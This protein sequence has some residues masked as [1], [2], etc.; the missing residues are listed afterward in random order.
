MHT[1]EGRA[2]WGL[3]DLDRSHQKPQPTPPAL[4]P[5]MVAG[6]DSDDLRVFGGHSRGKER[7]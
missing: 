5:S 3:G 4:L 2:A 6:L 1:S 7:E